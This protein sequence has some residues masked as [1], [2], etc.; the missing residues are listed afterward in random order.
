[1]LIGARERPRKGMDNYI[2][3]FDTPLGKG[4]FGMIKAGDNIKVS[5][6][7]GFFTNTVDIDRKKLVADLKTLLL[8][9]QAE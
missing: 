7:I 5:I 2:Y 6:K 9:I 1:M 3:D 8:W 4:Q